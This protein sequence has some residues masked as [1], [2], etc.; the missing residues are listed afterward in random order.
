MISDTVGEFTATFS[1]GDQFGYSVVGMGDND[2][3][4]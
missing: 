4:I 1:N 3:E 2:G